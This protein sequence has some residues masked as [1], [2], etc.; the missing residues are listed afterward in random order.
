MVTKDRKEYNRQYKLEHKEAIRDYAKAYSENNKEIIAQ[1]AKD[2]YDTHKEDISQRRKMHR[3][4]NHD[5]IYEKVPCDICGKSISKHNVSNHKK[6]AP[7][8][9]FTVTQQNIP[10]NI[11]IALKKDFPTITNEQIIKY[12]NTLTNLK[13]KKGS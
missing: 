8:Q 6:S 13:Q 5:K 2:Y 7:C 10:I 3:E 4:K 9:F 11:A 12:H 1:K